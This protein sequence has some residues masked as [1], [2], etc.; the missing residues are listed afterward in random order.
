[1]LPR[2]NL[3]HNKTDGGWDLKNQ[4]GDTIKWFAKKR[5]A[6]KGGVLE[7]AV[8]RGSV[9]IHGKSGQIE[10]ERTFPRGADPRRYPG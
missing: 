7:R 6:I 3:K 1:M 9:R 2:F 8:K 4:I 10:E 5:D